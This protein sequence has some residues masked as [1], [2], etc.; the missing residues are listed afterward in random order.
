MT[1]V[2]I[3]DHFVGDFGIKTGP[4]ALIE[5]TNV[6]GEITNCTSPYRM[7]MQPTNTFCLTTAGQGLCCYGGANFV[8]AGTNVQPTVAVT[9][10]ILT[11]GGSIVDSSIGRGSTAA[12]GFD[13]SINSGADGRIDKSQAW[14]AA[15]SGPGT[16]GAGFSL[17]LRGVLSQSAALSLASGASCVAMT[18]PDAVAIANQCGGS[19]ATG[20]SITAANGHAENNVIK[21][22]GGSGIGIDVEAAHATVNGNYVE[23]DGASAKGIKVNGYD[24][25]II[26]N[27]VIS[28]PA[29]TMQ[30]GIALGETGAGRIV[31]TDNTV[32]SQHDAAFW[33]QGG[34]GDRVA[35]NT[36]RLS[37][38]RPTAALHPIHFLDDNGSQVTIEGNYASGGWRGF[39]TGTGT[40]GLTNATLLGNRWVALA[41][42]PFAAGGAGVLIYDNYVNGTAG[43]GPTLVCDAS[44]AG[45][46]PVSRGILCTQD[47]DC[48]ANGNTC[49]DGV[50]KCIPEPASGFLCSPTAV[51]ESAHPNWTANLLF[52]SYGA[53]KQCGGMATSP[54]A[55]CTTSQG[56][57]GCGSPGTCTGGSEPY[58]TCTGGGADNNKLCCAG[59]APSCGYR[60]DTPYLRMVDYNQA[61]GGISDFVFNGNMLFPVSGQPNIHAIDFQSSAALGNIVI[62]RATI[63]GNDFSSGGNST[64]NSA[65]RMPTSFNTIVD[66]NISGNNFAG[67]WTKDVSN[68]TGRMGA[69]SFVPKTVGLASDQT[70]K[71]TSFVDVTGLTVRVDPNRTYS[72]RCDFTFTS[73]AATTGI[74]FAMVG[75][76]SPTTF[77]YMT[78]I[79][80]A[81][82]NG[83]NG[84]I[85]MIGNGDDATS[86]A[87][88]SVPAASTK[89]FA[90]IDGT[91]ITAASGGNLQARVKASNAHNVTV[92]AGS[93]CLVFQ[94][95][96]EEVH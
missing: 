50:Q 39:A 38:A 62:N 10:G 95:P 3:D 9:N 88:R 16:A 94:V 44:C 78:D 64:A 59:A 58:K 18:Q 1:N 30:Y 66:V 84:M 28:S 93:H 6:A 14:P 61:Y 32:T 13:T 31:A 90:R 19:Y 42:A 24:G 45:G 5:N 41:G 72:F 21:T 85:T 46:N 81:A 4:R 75:P 96:Q 26:G 71:S 57:G 76:P 87:T 53:M 29:D 74:A 43:G 8:G 77:N 67:P 70:T 11:A 55:L 79:T 86:R 47:S 36:T 68:F 12:I 2:Q 56:D 60:T 37:I 69:L 27:H 83:S 52:S 73:S 91:V 65:I 20:I 49:A 22:L 33:I 35:N 34:W 51:E 40:A 54:G 25:T 63:V 89:Y 17:G 15:A 80:Q 48:T 92:V 7:A 23:G 82:A